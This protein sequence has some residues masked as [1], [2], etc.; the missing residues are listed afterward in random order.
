M[1]S[2]AVIGT[3]SGNMDPNAAVGV[4]YKLYD[5]SNKLIVYVKDTMGA[6]HPAFWSDETKMKT[7]NKAVWDVWNKWRN[8]FKGFGPFNNAID[9]GN[10]HKEPFTVYLKPGE[11]KWEISNIGNTRIHFRGD[12]IGAK[13]DSLFC[14]Y[15]PKGQSRTR[16]FSIQYSQHTAL[17]LNTNNYSNGNNCGD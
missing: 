8:N 9:R 4:E 15:V 17:K 2:H 11:Y 16:N 5:S 10:N 1:P 13:G 14:D 3:D 6:Y 12:Y 7:H